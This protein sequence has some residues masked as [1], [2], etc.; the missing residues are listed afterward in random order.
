MSS[1]PVR[2]IELAVPKEKAVEMANALAGIDLRVDRCTRN[3][4]GQCAMFHDGR[5]FN[6]EVR[7]HDPAHV[8]DLQREK[9]YL[10]EN[11]ELLEW[12]Y[13]LLDETKFAAQ[14]PAN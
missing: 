3:P 8:F 4:Q 6:V 2:A 9:G 12:I 14:T 13:R 7:N 10:S 5:T 11:P 1:V